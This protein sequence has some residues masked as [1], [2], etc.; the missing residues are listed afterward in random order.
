VAKE[1]VL[2]RL[3]AALEHYAHGTCECDA[4]ASENSGANKLFLHLE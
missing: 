2:N 3:L 4:D 1:I